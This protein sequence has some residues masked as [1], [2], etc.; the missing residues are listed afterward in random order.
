MLVVSFWRWTVLL[1]IKGFLLLFLDLGS[2]Y[3]DVL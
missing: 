3:L 2:G 1:F